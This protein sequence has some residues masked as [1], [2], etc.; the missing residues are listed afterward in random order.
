VRAARGDVKWVRAT[1][2][3]MLIHLSTCGVN[4]EDCV[5]E[6]GGGRV[7]GDG[8]LVGEWAGHRRLGEWIGHRRRADRWPLGV[9]IDP[10]FHHA[11][12]KVRESSCAA[13]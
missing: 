1:F 12:K 11:G 4:R 3:E 13:G 10:R 8:R 5:K 9:G 6:A 2:D 7:G